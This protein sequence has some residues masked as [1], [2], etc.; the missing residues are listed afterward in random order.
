[1]T[2]YY[3]PKDIVVAP[4]IAPKNTAIRTI[5]HTLQGVSLEQQDLLETLIFFAHRL[6]AVVA[7]KLLLAGGLNRLTNQ[8]RVDW[9]RFMMSMQL[10]SPFSLGEVKRLTYENLRANLGSDDPEYSA[11]RKPDDPR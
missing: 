5:L 1:M 4:P 8:Q 11:I 9:A 2:R 3:R 7:H 6:D 10:R